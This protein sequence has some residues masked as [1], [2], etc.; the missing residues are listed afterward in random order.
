MILC[1]PRQPALIRIILT[2]MHVQY[3]QTIFRIKHN[4]HGDGDMITI[5]GFFLHSSLTGNYWEPEQSYIENSRGYMI[6]YDDEKVESKLSLLSLLFSGHNFFFFTR[7]LYI[8]E[9]GEN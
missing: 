2:C 8:I 1:I 3:R 7:A 5:V 6:R 4:E 9:Q